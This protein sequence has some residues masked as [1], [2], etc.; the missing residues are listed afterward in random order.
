MDYKEY[1]QLGERLERLLILRY[2]P[3]AMKLL[4]DGSEIPEGS[5]RP[6]KDLGGHLSMCQAYAM[7]RRERRA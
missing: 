2:S 7:V 5:L 4:Y 3:I 1:N 6:V